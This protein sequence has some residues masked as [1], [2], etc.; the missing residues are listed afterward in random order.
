VAERAAR[1]DLGH[2]M[3]AFAVVIAVYMALRIHA[4]GGLTGQVRRTGLGLATTLLT[5]AALAGEYVGKLVLPVRLSALHDHELVTGIADWRVGAGV[6]ALAALSAAA[7]RARRR[8]A[9]VLGLGLVLLPLAPSL[10]VAGLSESIFSERYLYLP[11]AGAALLLAIALDA[12]LPRAP[13][14]QIA[15]TAVLAVVVV[16]FSVVTVDRNAV[17]RDDVSLW[18][19]TARRM[20]HSAAA[21]EYYGYAL[22]VSGR[23]DAAVT[24]LHRALEI[25]PARL[26]ARVNLASALVRSG[27]PERAIPEIELALRVRPD[28]AVSH[29]VLG[30]ALASSGRLTEATDALAR[31]LHLDPGMAEVHNTLGAVLAALGRPGEA[32]EHFRRAAA[33]DPTNPLYARN[34]RLVAPR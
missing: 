7:W 2:A 5:A 24:T 3:L 23:A 20:P 1:R 33:L 8:P 15:C 30:E 31:A 27:R 26:D 4:L 32:V 9:V 14:A 17:W 16:V 22:L 12:W 25:D 13:G 10:Y 34:A 18:G 21:Q 29:A 19:D 28:S 6:V 11:S